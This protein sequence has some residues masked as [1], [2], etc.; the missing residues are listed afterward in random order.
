M[1]ESEHYRK[2]ASIRLSEYY[3]TKECIVM[4][5]VLMII[6]LI[7]NILAIPFVNS[8]H[9]VVLSMPFF[10]FWLLLWMVL[11]PLLTWWIYRIDNNRKKE[12]A[13]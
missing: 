13:H 8:I 6:M 9:P 11:T 4:R 12:R 10:L 5:A 1:A 3:E 7:G 2:T